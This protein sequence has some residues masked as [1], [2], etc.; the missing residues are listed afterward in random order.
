MIGITSRRPAQTVLAEAL[1]KTATLR[2]SRCRTGLSPHAPYST[3]AELLHLTAKAVRR[4][5][6]ICTHVAESAVEYQMF[7][8]GQGEM[9]DWMKRSGRD[10]A[11]CGLGSP[12]QHLERS[13]LLAGNVLAVHVNYVGRN[14]ASVLARRGVKVVHCPRSHSYF[15]HE[16]FPLRRLV[17]AGVNV[18]LGTDSLA[19]VAKMRH[20]PVELSMFEELRALAGREPSLSARQC[21]RMAT[22]NGARALR[23]EGQIGEL[24]PGALADLIVVPSQGKGPAI[25]ERVLEHHGHVTAS[26]IGG[27]WAIPPEGSQAGRGKAEGEV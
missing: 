15:R 4:R 14:D 2:H 6:M 10:M 17:R 18:C 3:T 20:Q 9:F 13:G 12:V 26:M 7:T 16:P 21:L 5:Q 24:A 8:F 22:V 25:Y 19:T 23:M 27:R 1:A 11:D